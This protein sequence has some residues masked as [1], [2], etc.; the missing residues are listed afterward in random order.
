MPGVG[1]HLL[2]SLPLGE[3]AQALLAG[4]HTGVDD[5]Q[6]QLP[7]AGVENEDGAVDRLCRQV[8]LEGLVNSH[9]ARI[10]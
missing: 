8:T 9:P 3:L 2:G 6:E 4:P 7:G 5:L 10:N 1:A